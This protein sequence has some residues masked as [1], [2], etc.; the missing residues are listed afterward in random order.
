[1]K[2]A[3][4]TAWLIWIV[5]TILVAGG[6]FYY[7]QYVK[8]PELNNHI[9]SLEEQLRQLEKELATKNAVKQL[10]DKANLYSVE[11]QNDW[12]ITANEGEKGVQRSFITAESPDF[13]SRIDDTIGGPFDAIYFEKGA[14]LTIHVTK[15]KEEL[16]HS[17][18]GGGKETG[19][20]SK[21]NITLDGVNGTYYIFK[22]PSTYQGQLIDAYAIYK[23]NSYLLRLAYNPDTYPQGE[24]IFENII[25]SFRFIK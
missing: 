2:K 17:G 14:Q 23:N 6:I 24:K 12:K 8:I 15:G 5:I 25:N 22:E 18:E 10:T 13:K 7:Y 16:T 3:S 19:V 21:K 20:I 1:M 11:I 9:S 4:A